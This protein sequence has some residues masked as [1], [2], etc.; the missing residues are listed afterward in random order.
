MPP[1]DDFEIDLGSKDMQFI[2]DPAKNNIV[3]TNIMGSMC[4]ILKLNRTSTIT[5]ISIAM[6]TA[7][8]IKNK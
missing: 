6:I 5:L 8:I 2:L 7:K 3:V 4:F 1:I